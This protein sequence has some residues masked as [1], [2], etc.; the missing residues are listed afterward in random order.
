M[1]VEGER[2]KYKAMLRYMARVV[3]KDAGKDA[4]EVEAKL[5]PEWLNAMV[6]K[7]A[8]R[9]CARCVVCR[10]VTA[11]MPYCAITHPVIVCN[12]PLRYCARRNGR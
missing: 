6:S 5:S 1:A 4:D 3:A 2:T 9:S 10:R 11:R 7:A 8:A 12:V